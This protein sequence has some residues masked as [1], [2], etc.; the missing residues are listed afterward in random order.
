MFRFLRTRLIDKRLVQTSH[1]TVGVQAASQEVAAQQVSVRAVA[2]S[3]GHRVVCSVVCVCVSYEHHPLGLLASGNAAP[4]EIRSQSGCRSIIQ[5]Q[6]GRKPNPHE[7]QRKKK[8]NTAPLFGGSDRQR[9]TWNT[10]VCKIS[11]RISRKPRVFSGLLCG[12]PL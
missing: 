3:R 8:K 1:P 4:V 7:K 10:A 5:R 11:G 6:A 9:L 12:N 2:W